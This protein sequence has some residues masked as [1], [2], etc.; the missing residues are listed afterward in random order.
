MDP[1]IRIFP[2]AAQLNRVLAENLLKF[3]LEKSKLKQNVY[4]ALS[5]GNTPK[6]FFMQLAS[7][8]S[9]AGNQT[10]WSH[11][12]F[13]WVD[14]RC[15]IPEHEDSNFGMAKRH[16]L[17]SMNINE[18][19]IHRIMGENEPH[20]EAERYTEE[21]RRSVPVRDGLPR[22]DWILLGLGTDG[23]T[24]SIFPD[25]PDL[26]D[27]ENICALVKHPLTGQQRI[28][29]TCK[30]INNAATICF[31]VSGS[32]KREIVSHITVQSGNTNQYPAGNIRPFNGKLEWY[33]DKKA[34][35]YVGQQ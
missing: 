13:F 1:L 30:I 12:H 21:I 8:I 11:V 28:T 20:F 25:R 15:V 4:L 22:F 9:D 34:A 17:N 16:L 3:L 10:D 23:H 14:E 24:A 6:Q 18:D 7:Y 29:L 33:I 31:L 5:G 19:L 26:I 27:T 32:S 35:E 2:T